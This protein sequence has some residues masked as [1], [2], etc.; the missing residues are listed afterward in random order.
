VRRKAEVFWGGFG[1]ASLKE[2][3]GA[4]KKRW[5]RGVFERKKEK[6]N[7]APGL[8]KGGASGMAS[9]TRKDLGEFGKKKQRPLPCDGKKTF[10]LNSGLLQKFE[11]QEQET[12]PLN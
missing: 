7:K 5:T 10:R 3:G 8:K 4:L 2:K 9:K 11:H 1:G 6:Q 12:P